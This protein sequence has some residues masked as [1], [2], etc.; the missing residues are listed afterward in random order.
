MAADPR[1]NIFRHEFDRT[2]HKPA[3]SEAAMASENRLRMDTHAHTKSYIFTFLSLPV[4]CTFW[5]WLVAYSTA[6]VP[7]DCIS[8]S[9][10]RCV[11]V[12]NSPYPKCVHSAALIRGDFV[13]LLAFLRDLSQNSSAHC[14][15][16]V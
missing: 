9:A 16:C 8:D 12:E 5:R 1:Q 4:H 6:Y 15:H 2:G 11:P 10:M 14:V 7:C 13:E 3:D